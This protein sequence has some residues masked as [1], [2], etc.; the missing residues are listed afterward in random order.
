MTLLHNWQTTPSDQH[1]LVRLGRLLQ[2]A[3]YAYTT[4]SPPSHR[5]VNAR[6]HHASAHDL[7][8]VFGWNRPFDASVVGPEILQLMDRAGIL[9]ADGSQYRSA[10]RASTLGGQLY[11][12]SAYPTHDVDSVFFGPD[13]YRYESVIGAALADGRPVMRAVDIGSGAGPGAV[14]VARARPQAQVWAVDINPRALAL[15]ALNARLAGV[16]NVQVALSNL[17]DG[18]E[19]QFD[20]IVANPPFMVDDDQRTYCHGGGELGE[21]LSHAIVDSAIARLAPG[22]RLVLYTCVA[23]IDGADP[24]RQQAGERLTAA[25]CQWQYRELD[26]DVFGGELGDDLHC[27]TDRIAAIALVATRTAA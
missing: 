18:V 10:L 24:F 14:M 25:G 3:G 16:D 20:L 4:I 21:G 7:R 27:H 15:T 19:G 5:R 23:I 11:F 17:L 12:H 22:G 13:T 2:H 26:P 1:P 8:G 9:V 6:E